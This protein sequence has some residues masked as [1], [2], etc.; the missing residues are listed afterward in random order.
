MVVLFFIFKGSCILFSMVPAP[1]YILISSAQDFLSSILTNTFYFLPFLLI[2]ILIGMRWY[3]TVDLICISL[4][5]WTSF[6]VYWP[7]L[8]HLWKTVYLDV[9]LIFNWT[10]FFF[11]YLTNSFYI[12]HTYHFY[13]PQT[14]RTILN[15]ECYMT[16]R[17]HCYLATYEG[18][19]SLWN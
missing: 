14:P 11:L 8:C 7:S 16:E 4:I 10:V 2:A 3:L 18:P 6:C 9:L 1:I 15:L 12:W 17:S 5:S 13:T 19:R